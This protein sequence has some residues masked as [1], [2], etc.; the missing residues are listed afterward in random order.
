[1]IFILPTDTCYWIGC[2]TDNIEDYK[3]IYEIKNRS[4]SK[5]LAIFLNN[6]DEIEKYAYISEK[7]LDF[8]KKYNHPFTVLLKIKD[9]KLIE[10][11]P[12]KDNYKKIAFRIAD[13]IVLKNYTKKWPIFLTSANFSWELEMYNNLDLKN[14]FKNYLEEVEIDD[15]IKEIPINKPSN[16]F[17]FIDDNDK[18]NVNIKYLR[19]NY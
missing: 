7:Q 18:N 6:F 11:L 2:Y 14:K 10:K 17:E 3:R 5:P 15:T 9:K 4:F 16:I 1:M 19:K 13:N 8:L 12:N